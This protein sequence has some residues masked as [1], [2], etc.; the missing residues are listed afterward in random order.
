MAYFGVPGPRDGRNE[1]VSCAD[2]PLD[3][4]GIGRGRFGGLCGC[5]AS[6]KPFPFL[7]SHKFTHPGETDIVNGQG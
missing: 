3:S 4:T 5:S 2:G 6:F 1:S 7:N